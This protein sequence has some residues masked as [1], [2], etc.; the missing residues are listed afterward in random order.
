MT[1]LQ[2][3]R[4]WPTLRAHYCSIGDTVHQTHQAEHD[5]NIKIWINLTLVWTTKASQ[6]QLTLKIMSSIFLIHIYLKVLFVEMY[7]FKIWMIIKGFKVSK[8]EVF[9]NVSPQ[10]EEWGEKSGGGVSKCVFLSSQQPW[11]RTCLFEF[12]STKLI[13]MPSKILRKIPVLIADGQDISLQKW[14]KRHDLQYF[15]HLIWWD[16]FE[17][18]RRTLFCFYDSYS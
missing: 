1:Y 16:I 2:C 12:C 5:Q 8:L 10:Q 3:C 17:A 15:W 11:V 4:V 6:K 14:G 7:F 9:V 13:F 18:N